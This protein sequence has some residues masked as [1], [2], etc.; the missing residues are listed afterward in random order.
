[1]SMKNSMTPLGIQP[2]TFGLVAQCLNQLRDRVLRNH[3][4]EFVNV[5]TGGGM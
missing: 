1:M 5:K 4:V 3:H 2:V